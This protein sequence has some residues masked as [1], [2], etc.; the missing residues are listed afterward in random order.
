MQG[1]G[2]RQGGAQDNFRLVVTLA[3]DQPPP[4]VG[5][6]IQQDV[7]G[8][9]GFGGLVGYPQQGLAFVDAAEH[10]DCPRL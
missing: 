2:A 8:I 7:F 5:F 9:G 6:D 1:A 3:A 10:Q 4:L